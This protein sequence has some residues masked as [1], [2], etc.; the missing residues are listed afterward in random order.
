MKPDHV[1]SVLKTLR[2][3]LI[4]LRVKAGAFTM[5]YMA[6]HH[7]LPSSHPI[8]LPHSFNTVSLT[9]SA[10]ASLLFLTQARHTPP[11]GHLHVL[12]SLP[13]TLFL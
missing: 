7:L 1:T 8:S 10:L 12:L 9:H 2:W 11:A 6:L 3:F 13:Q 4:L 5:A